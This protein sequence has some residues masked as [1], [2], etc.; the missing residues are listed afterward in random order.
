MKPLKKLA[1]MATTEKPMDVIA[2]L[3]ADH[4]KVEGL[5]KDFESAR[6]K[7]QRVKLINEIVK[8]LS[9]HA[10]VEEKLV[11]PQLEQDEKELTGEA[12]E[13]HHLVKLVIAELADYD[14]SEENLESKIKVL[15]ELVKHH[16][17][18]EER[19]MLPKL[20]ES[21]A[22][23]MKM[24]QK[25]Q[26]EKQKLLTSMQKVGDKSKRQI[27]GAPKKSTRATAVR[28]AS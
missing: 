24:A 3:K 21:G 2:L 13:E 14:G 17:K 1:G 7:L 4:R 5:F 28:K 23:L 16:V 20:K 25:V 18:E 8:E 22:D 27:G 6:T 12:L 19:E 11:Y 15:S 9:V 10:T 26:A